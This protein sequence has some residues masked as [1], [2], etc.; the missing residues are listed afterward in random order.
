MSLLCGFCHR[1][2]NSVEIQE[3]KSPSN[4]FT[5]INTHLEV[6]SRENCV[7][8]GDFLV[9]WRFYVA[10]NKPCWISGFKG[11]NVSTCTHCKCA[12]Y[13]L[14]FWRC[15]QCNPIVEIVTTWAQ[16]EISSS[17]EWQN[18]QAKIAP[19]ESMSPTIIMLCPCPR[20][21]IIWNSRL[22]N[23]QL[24]ECVGGS[25]DERTL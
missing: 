9:P 25:A 20:L 7:S 16:L 23:K 5:L 15:Q 21:A 12:V 8:V 6:R 1:L 24:S 14:Q 22:R 3:A 18:K 17:P 10:R 11:T 2:P 13:V 4:R 19:R